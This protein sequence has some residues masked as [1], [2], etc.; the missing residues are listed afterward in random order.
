MQ[1]KFEKLLRMPD[2]GDGVATERFGGWMRCGGG[3]D[4]ILGRGSNAGLAPTVLSVTPVPNAT[5]VPIN[6]KIVTVA[7]SEAMDPASLSTA[8]VTLACPAGAPVT[9]AVSYQAA[10]N[11]ATLTLPA[12]TNL[13]ASTLCIATVTT[14][15]KNAAGIPLDSNFGWTFTTGLVPDTTAPT[16]T[17]TIHTNGQ[18]NVAL[19]TKVGTTFS[20]VMDPLTINATTFTLKQGTT[21]VPGTVTYA[22]INAVFTPTSNLAPSTTYT[23]TVTT[24]AKDVRG[25]SLASKLRHQLDHRCSSRHHRPNGHRHCQCQRRDQRRRQHP[26]GRNIQ[27]GD[28]S[29]DDHQRECLL[30]HRRRRRGTGHRQLLRCEHGI[31]AIKQSCQQRPL[32]RHHQGGINGVTDLAGNPMVADFKYAWTTAA[33]PDTTAPTVTGAIHVN[34]QTNVAINTA[35]GATFSEAM[36]PL[37]ITN[38]NVSLTTDAAA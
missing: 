24:G 23:V 9:G 10:N 37:T 36:N 4:P 15:A 22:G 28:G 1:N 33:A 17:G 38:A 21:A 31:P 30:D 20:E 16:V 3:E 18:T 19:N 14:G 7:F 11:L 13:P 12:A 27:Q 5:G 32:Q 29:V 35:I 6:T 25:N 2:V 8:S 26:G 34:G